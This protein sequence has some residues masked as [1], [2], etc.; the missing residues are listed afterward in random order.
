M[1]NNKALKALIQE[2]PRVVHKNKNVYLIL[3]ECRIKTKEG[4][5]DGILYIN[6]DL[7]EGPFVRVKSEF[8]EKFRPME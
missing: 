8:E 7:S 6:E 1:Q 3:S 5:V 4:W 2:K